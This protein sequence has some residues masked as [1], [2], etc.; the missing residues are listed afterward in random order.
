MASSRTYVTTAHGSK[1]LQ[2]L[3]KHW[4]HRLEVSFT[5]EQ[6]SI[7]FDGGRDCRL[8]A[9]ENGLEINASAPDAETL[10][11]TQRTIIEHLKRFAF[12]ENLDG[13]AWVPVQS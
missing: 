7:R 1:Y 2:Q 5:P 6:G 9:D 8:R 12:R 11:R 13:V 4:S 10:E 3:C